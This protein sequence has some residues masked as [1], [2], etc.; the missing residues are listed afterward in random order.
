MNVVCI[1]RK[2]A[3]HGDYV[4]VVSLTYDEIVMIGNALYKKQYDT[5]PGVAQA[6]YCSLYGAWK[7]FRDMTCYGH[8]CRER[9]DVENPR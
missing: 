8:I 6:R 9:D 1:D 2:A 5:E 4:G 7:D 3:N